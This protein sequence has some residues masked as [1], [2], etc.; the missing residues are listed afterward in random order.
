VREYEESVQLNQ[1]EDLK[2]PGTQMGLEERVA[3]SQEGKKAL[4]VKKAF[5]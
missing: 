5:L 2:E 3:W 4:R 1:Q